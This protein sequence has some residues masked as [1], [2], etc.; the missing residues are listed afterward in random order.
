CGY[1]PRRPGR[2]A[3]RVE[4]E[5]LVPAH[6][7]GGQRPCWRRRACTDSRGRRFG[8]RRCCRQRDPE[9]A[10]MEADLMNLS[11][12][13]GELNAD[14]SHFAFGEVPGEARRYGRCDFDVD[15]DTDTVEPA[16]SI[17]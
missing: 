3:R 10:R 1:E 15:R 5:H 12:E 17:R 4:W 7:L 16:P 6:T 14:R 8:G 13:I 2:R 11:P 9:F